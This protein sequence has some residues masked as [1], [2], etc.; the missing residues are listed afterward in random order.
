GTG[1]QD[2]GTVLHCAAWRGDAR[3]VAAALRYESVRAIINRKDPTHGGTPLGWCVHGAHN[4][5]IPGGDP[6]AVARMLLD[7]GAEPGT[8]LDEMP[9]AVRVA[10]GM[11]GGRPPER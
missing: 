11:G 3:C 8:Y 7:A 5:S 9:R 2:G 6:A 4:A 10:M 1:G